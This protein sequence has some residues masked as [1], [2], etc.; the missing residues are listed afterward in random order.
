MNRREVL[1][2]S[3]SALGFMALDGLPVFAA[4]QGWKHGGK[5]NLVFGALSDTHLQVNYNGVSPHGRFPIK[6]LRKALENYK[7]RNIDALVHCGDMA[8]RGMV[9][10]LEF[11]QEL[12]D[13]VFGKGKGPVK[14]FV[15]GN[16]EWF[17]D[18]EG[19]GGVCGRRL[20]PDAVERAE[21]TICGDFPRHCERVFGEPYE[22][23]WHK[24]VKCYHFFGHF[25]QSNADWRTIYYDA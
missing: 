7:S 8:H 2:G 16:H 19:F 5:P 3:L 9:R 22:E 25:H 10:E 14:L 21:H 1:K 24:E 15:A 12:I 18:G 13:E 6:Y 17:G 4:P 20:Y 11:H 23:C